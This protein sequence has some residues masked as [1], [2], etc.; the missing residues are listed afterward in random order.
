MKVLIVDKTGV[1]DS[2]HER[3]TQLAAI[4]EMQLSLVTPTQWLESGRVVRWEPRKDARYKVCPLRA[5][6][7]GNYARGFY[8]KGLS[9]VF[10][11]SQ[12]DVIQLLEEPWSFFTAQALWAQKKA[13]EHTRLLFYTWENIYRERTYP[14]RV[15]F[16]YRWIERSCHRRFHGGVCATETARD[17]LLRKGFSKPTAVIPYGID[18]SF[19]ATTATPKRQARTALHL[20]DDFLVGYVGRLLPMKGIEVL[21]QAFADLEQGRLLIVGTGE[22]ERDLKDMVLKLD[23]EDRVL[24]MGSVAHEDAPLIMRALDVLVLPSRTTPHWKEQLGRVLLEAM[25]T[26]T[27]VIGSSSGAIPEVI[28][29][30]GL[31]FQEDDAKALTE[32]I[33]HLQ[34]EPAL[35]DEL[36]AKG[37]ER[38]RNRFTWER[39]SQD[40]SNFWKSLE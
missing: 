5:R 15:S 33:E 10:H 24:F 3:C 21:I 19:A 17:V 7:Q 31:V 34:S 32:A 38:V 36:R 39:F 29:D 16:V 27:V 26:E 9:E 4:E 12:P 2:A 28:G 30:A 11:Q 6:F 35:M 25:A 18:A 37:V 40:I 14:A 22:Q 1:M 13:P 20:P 23:L 8:Q